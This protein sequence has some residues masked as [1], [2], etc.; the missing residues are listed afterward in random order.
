VSFA[1]GA[2]ALIGEH[3]EVCN[4]GTTLLAEAKLLLGVT[5]GRIDGVRNM[6]ACI[7]NE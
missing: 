2:L 6:A 7:F 4:L 3:L 5:R 1:T